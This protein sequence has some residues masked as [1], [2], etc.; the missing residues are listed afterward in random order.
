MLIK[1]SVLLAKK[2]TTYNTDP[3]P[4]AAND[5]VYV[6]NLSHGPA[7]QKMHEQS[8]VKN[9]LGKHKSLYGSHLW[10]ITFDVL[11]K[12]S[13]TAGAAPEYG[14]LLEACGFDETIVASTSV[15]YDPLSTSIESAT[16]Y[17]FED[18][19]RYNITGCRGNVSFS[20]EGGQAG[21]LSFTLTGHFAGDSDVSLPSPTL[22]STEAPIIKSAGFTVN[23]YSASISKLDFDMGNEVASPVDVNASDAY[24]EII[25]TDRDVNGSIDPLDVLL[26]TEDFMA[27]WE[28]GTEMALSTGTIGSSAGNRYAISMPAVSYRDIAL[29]DRDGQR[30]ME[31]PF[32]AHESSGDDGVSIS[33][34]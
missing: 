1:K 32:G 5:A 26:A 28:A 33:F 17:L 6:E 8:G 21:K 11:V 9:T 4:A 13:G 34:S 29:G 31:L 14:P 27:D 25:I 22:D 15:T 23:S 19:K 3:T 10:Q 7:G 12:G 16:I 24:G 18:G 2:E 30:I 20:G